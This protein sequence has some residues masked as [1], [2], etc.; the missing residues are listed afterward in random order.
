MGSPQ[1]ISA[2]A[3][4]RKTCHVHIRKATND[5]SFILYDLHIKS[6]KHYCASFYSDSAISSWIASK[7]PSAYI[8]LPDSTIILIAEIR[9]KTIGFGM[10]NLS[11]QS[12]DSL[13]FLPG[14]CGNGYGRILLE[15]LESTAEKNNLNEL[16]LNSTLNAVDFYN[17]MG[18]SCNV[19]TTFALR[20]GT[21]LNC[22]SMKKKLMHTVNLYDT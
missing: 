14:Y 1:C 5:D 6:I 4:Y 18:Y 8:N 2:T 20:S 17:H 13:Y 10:I 3:D 15:A 9:R 22:V 19:P 16:C 12:I 7:K 21:K 11:T